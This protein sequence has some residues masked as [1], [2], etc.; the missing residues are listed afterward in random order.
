MV[1]AFDMSKRVSN[2]KGEHAGARCKGVRIGYW[3]KRNLKALKAQ[4][5]AMAKA[6]MEKK[7]TT[8][9]QKE[10][11]GSLAYLGQQFREL[12]PKSMRRRHQSR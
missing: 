5:K 11:L 12:L 3:R 4:Q 2:K 9:E 6:L 10:I 1:G 7:H 8:E